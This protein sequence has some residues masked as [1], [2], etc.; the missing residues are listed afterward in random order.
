MI[1][2][3]EGLDAAGKTTLMTR[4]RSILES[5][6]YRVSA[7]KTPSSSKTGELA[8]TYGND[9]E[10]DHLTRM[11]LFLANTSD[12][13]R[14]LKRII[15]EES[16][17]FLFIDRYYLCSMAYGFALSML[18]GTRVSKQDFKIFLELVERLG[19]GVFVRPDV[20]LIIDVL[21]EDRIRRLE[22]KEGQGGL[23]SVLERDPLMQRYVRELYQV[24]REMRPDKV[25]WI[26]N[27]Q[28]EVDAVADKIVNL[29][30]ERF[31]KRI[32]QD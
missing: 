10:I 11:L 2:V 21:E 23:E 14:I 6:S 1:V 30:L 9:P 17:D 16:P 15:E 7:H 8:K 3:W 32:T 20:Y 12:D 4:V 29:L 19:E 18:R 28:G 5:K 25:A 26:M 13:S 24:F 22:M 27:P 31:S